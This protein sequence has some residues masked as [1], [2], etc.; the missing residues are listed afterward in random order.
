MTRGFLLAILGLVVFGG[1]ALA[2]VAFLLAWEAGK[3][4]SIEYCTPDEQVTIVVTSEQAWQ[5]ILYA[6]GDAEIES[7]LQPL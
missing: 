5:H 2:W 3:R 1:V 7:E 4:A 6:M